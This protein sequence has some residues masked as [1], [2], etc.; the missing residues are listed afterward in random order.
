MQINVGALVLCVIDIINKGWF[1]IM[2][3]VLFKK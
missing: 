3:E 2:A 1:L